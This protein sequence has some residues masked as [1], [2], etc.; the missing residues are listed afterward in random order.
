MSPPFSQRVSQD[1]C[2]SKLWES[3]SR[4]KGATKASLFVM[5]KRRALVQQAFKVEPKGWGWRGKQLGRPTGRQ[6]WEP[7]DGR[8]AAQRSWDWRYQKAVCQGPLNSET[9]PPMQEVWRCGQ[10]E[11]Q[12]LTSLFFCNTQLTLRQKNRTLA[13]DSNNSGA[14]GGLSRQSIWLR[15]R[16]S[17]H[18]S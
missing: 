6:V 16:S 2:S 7:Y 8:G 14:P 4:H 5:G 15:L 12:E 3:Y 1:W 13:L 17:S 10:K 18:G 11:N 9:L